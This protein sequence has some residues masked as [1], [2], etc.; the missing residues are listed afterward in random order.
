MFDMILVHPVNNRTYAKVYSADGV[1]FSTITGVSHLE[2]AKDGYI[3]KSIFYYGE[4]ATL[5]KYYEN[6]RREL[7]FEIALL[8]V[9]G[10]MLSAKKFETT[11]KSIGKF[12]KELIEVAETYNIEVQE[13]IY[14]ASNF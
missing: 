6:I 8:E 11:S 9:Y 4:F 1:N 14:E 2:L 3:T 5:K 7:I 12:A 10:D 13:L